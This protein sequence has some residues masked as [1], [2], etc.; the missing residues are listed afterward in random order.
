MAGVVPL[1]LADEEE[2]VGGAGDEG[3][4]FFLD[5]GAQS[6]SPLCEEGALLLSFLSLVPGEEGLSA[7]EPFLP[8]PSLDARRSSLP[9]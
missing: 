2:A 1:L 5:G 9:L 8:G 4:R 3:R 6:S 7:D